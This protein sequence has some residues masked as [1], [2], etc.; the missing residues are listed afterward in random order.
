MPRG[1]PHEVNERE[2]VFEN[3]DIQNRFVLDLGAGTLRFS[4]EALKRGAKK[5]VALDASRELLVWGMEKVK[6]IGMQSKTDAIIAD[7]RKLPFRNDIADIIIAVELFEHLATGKMLF[8]NEVYR[9]LARRGMAAINTWNAMPKIIGGLLGITKRDR[10]FW[11]G[12]FYYRYDF[13]WEFSN[14]ISSIGF[15]ETKLIGVHS[16]Y[17]FP[18]LERMSFVDLLEASKLIKIFVFVEITADKLLRKIAPLNLVTGA[19]LL[20]I[21]R[22]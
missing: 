1:I 6:G 17:L 10:A 12:P 2:S 15:S 19:F 20:A 22:K 8:L 7:V 21:L 14:Y 4:L 9:V 11:K 16:T 3:L 18:Q 5:V 13:P